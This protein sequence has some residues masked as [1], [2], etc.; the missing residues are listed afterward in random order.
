MNLEI[1]FVSREKS[2][3][4]K[5]SAGGKFAFGRRFFHVKLYFCEV[6]RN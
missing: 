1:R 3:M 6:S 4:G 5:A 2:S